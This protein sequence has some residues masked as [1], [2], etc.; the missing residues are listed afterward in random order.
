M[1]GR[2]MRRRLWYSGTVYAEL[3]DGHDL[4]AVKILEAFGGYSTV[5]QKRHFSQHDR[6]A[7]RMRSCD[8]L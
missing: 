5:R 3:E 1:L 7:L 6:V 4:A 8:I 2:M